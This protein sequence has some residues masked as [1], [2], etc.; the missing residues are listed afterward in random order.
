MRAIRTYGLTERLLVRAPRDGLGSTPPG[1][2]ARGRRPMP[3][4][5][6]AAITTRRHVQHRTLHENEKCS[7]D[8]SEGQLFYETLHAVDVAQQGGYGGARDNDASV[9]VA[10][11]AVGVALCEDGGVEVGADHFAS[12]VDRR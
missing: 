4:A 1:A 11:V 5:R 10:I 9:D 12:F 2:S 7:A 3:A 6:E 8:L